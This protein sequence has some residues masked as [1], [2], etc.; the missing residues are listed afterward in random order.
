MKIPGLWLL[1]R[2]GRVVGWPL[3]QH[4]N[5]NHKWEKAQ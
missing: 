4:A 1:F 3:P 2:I 5:D